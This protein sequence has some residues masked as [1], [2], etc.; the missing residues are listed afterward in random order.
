MSWLVI[1]H[2]RVVSRYMVYLINLY[3]D[4]VEVVKC[5]PSHV[6]AYCHKLYNMARVVAIRGVALLEFGFDNKQGNLEFA[7]GN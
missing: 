4:P 3:S 7:A 5:Q 1:S 6:S 2:V